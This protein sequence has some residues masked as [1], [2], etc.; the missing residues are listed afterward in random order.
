M[1]G[2]YLKSALSQ[3]FFMLH[4]KTMNALEIFVNADERSD[5]ELSTADNSVVTNIIGNVGVISIEG[6]MYKKSAVGL[7]TSVLSYGDI[8]TEIK[9]MENNEQVD[10]V[11]YLVDTPG[12]VVT[13]AADEVADLI[14]N[15]SKKT[16]AIAKD[17]MASGG[18]WIFSACDEIYASSN[19][20]EFG[21]VGVRG[22]FVEEKDEKKIYKA[23]SKN[24]KNKDCS[25]SGKCKEKLHTQ[26]DTIEEE[27]YSRLEKNTGFNKDF[28][29]KEF[30][31]GD[32]IFAPQAIK[33]GFIKDIISVDN[34]ISSL[35]VSANSANEAVPSKEKPAAN[36][37]TK[38]NAMAEEQTDIEQAVAEATERAV[39][40][41]ALGSQYGVSAEAVH[42]AIA[43]G[44]TVS[45]FKD[46][47]L[48]ALNDRAVTAEANGADV[49]ARL[50]AAIK[51]GASEDTGATQTPKAEETEGKN[52]AVLDAASKVEV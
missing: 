1:R 45:E 23:V 6:A 47:A 16:I 52:Q 22:G 15:S 9:K 10:T 8:K 32:T 29:I 27:F 38:E 36:Q 7:C 35:V 34:F 24:A 37:K 43:E 51:A 17:T 11:V 30:N 13:D 14:L 42:T 5:V 20:T 33:I 26:L 21:S 31:E 40:I 18:M 48:E 50:D 2:D 44:K 41:A 46:V 3:E 4:P 25:L 28:F 19:L 39:M 12:G 49:Q